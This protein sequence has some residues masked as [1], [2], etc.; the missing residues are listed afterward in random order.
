MSKELW[1]PTT[2]TSVRVQHHDIT[3]W[4]DIQFEKRKLKTPVLPPAP[5][6]KPPVPSVRRK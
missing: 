6:P 5:P 3:I 2:I 4:D 1:L